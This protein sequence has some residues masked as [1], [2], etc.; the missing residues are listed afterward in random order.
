MKH[1]L[2]L[3]LLNAAIV[4]LLLPGAAFAGGKATLI[5][6]NPG[7]QVGGGSYGGGETRAIVSWRDADTVRIDEDQSHYS[8]LRDGKKY[9]ISQSH[10]ETKVMD[11]PMAGEPDSEEVDQNPFSIE[12]T[13]ATE[14]VAGIEG[15]VYKVSITIR[16]LA[17]MP[18]TPCIRMIR[19]KATSLL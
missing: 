16:T 7:M 9:W 18:S 8:L 10:G 3:S 19:D 14:T 13:G 11:M 6:T 5:K 4:S 15:R 1:R 12:A 17:A 2:A